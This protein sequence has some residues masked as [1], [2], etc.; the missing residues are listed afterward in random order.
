V[1]RP[2][3]LHDSADLELNEA[4][5]YY[6]LES[7]GLG[8]AFLADVERG[9]GQIREHP[10]AAPEVAPGVRKLVLA[11]FPFTIVY[12]TRTDTIRVLAIAHQRKRPFYWRGRG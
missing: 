3:R 2:L 8:E 4:A 6:D 5:D 10:D 1:T 12:G 11:R 7:P 9:F